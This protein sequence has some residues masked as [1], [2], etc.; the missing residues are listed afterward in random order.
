MKD[1]DIKT[2][3]I[4]YLFLVPILFTFCTHIIAAEHYTLR[5]NSERI[6]QSASLD[7]I[8]EAINDPRTFI[9]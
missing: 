1:T 9:K 3:V 2:H 8:E 5:L 7:K 4:V 6:L